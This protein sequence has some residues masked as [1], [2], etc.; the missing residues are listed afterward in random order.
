MVQDTSS[1]SLAGG[2]LTALVSAVLLLT[3]KYS[4]TWFPL[5]TNSAAFWAYFLGYGFLGTAATYIICQTS[6]GATPVLTIPASI[7]W[8]LA[9]GLIGTLAKTK[10]VG[11]MPGGDQFDVTIRAALVLFEPE[12]LSRMVDDEFFA[13]R[14]IIRKYAPE[15]DLRAVKDAIAAGTPDRMEPG[16]RLVFLDEIEKCQTVDDAMIRYLRLVGP[17]WFREVFADVRPDLQLKLFDRSELA[18]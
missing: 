2:V 12:L 13:L 3:T 1:L 18:A 14:K 9:V 8:P 15:C 6:W 7:F 10:L 17:R 5:I 16:K 11:M 4:R